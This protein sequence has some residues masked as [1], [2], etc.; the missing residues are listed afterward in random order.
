MFA[1]Y[2][3]YVR[4]QK[5]RMLIVDCEKAFDVRFQVKSSF[6]S[7]ACLDVHLRV[8]WEKNW[9]T[10]GPSPKPS[11]YETGALPSAE[12]ICW[13][14]YL[15]YEQAKSTLYTILVMTFAPLSWTYASVQLHSK[16]RQSGWGCWNTFKEEYTEIVYLDYSWES[17]IILLSLFSEFY[18]VFRV[19]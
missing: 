6:K 12:T 13:R 19:I 18:A 2:P 15:I 8:D 11:A 5:Y 17:F 1:R 4:R 14:Y 16:D 10:R 7:R 3:K 9:V